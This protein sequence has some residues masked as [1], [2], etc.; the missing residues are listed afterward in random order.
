MSE[1]QERRE[2]CRRGVRTFLAERQAVTHRLSAIRRGVNREGNDFTER[3]ITDALVFLAGEK[4]VEITPDPD[5]ATLYYQA[6]S[7]GVLAH[8]RRGG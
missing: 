4:H 7:A 2:D 1:A 5:G 3:E 6:T 8:E